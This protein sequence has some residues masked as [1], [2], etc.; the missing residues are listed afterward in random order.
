MKVLFV[1]E[2]AEDHDVV[3]SILKRDFPEVK[4]VGFKGRRGIF[5]HLVLD[6]AF[7]LM[8]LECRSDKY[9]P[10]ELSEDIIKSFGNRRFLFVGDKEILE[11]TIVS[12]V[13]LRKS[14]FDIYEKPYSQSQFVELLQNILRDV[15][16]GQI[17]QILKVNSK[18]LF[19]MGVKN[20][21]LFSKVPHD[22]FVELSQNKFI[23][24]ISKNESYPQHIIKELVGRNVRE[25]Y[26]EKT[27]YIRF[28]EESM[29]SAGMLMF[30][31]EC[32]PVKIFQIQ[33]SSLDLIHQYVK[34]IGVS[35]TV[36]DL[37]DKVIDA[38]EENIGA[39]E[40]FYD[41]FYMFPFEERDVVEK[42]ILI[43]Y[44]CEMIVRSLKWNSE[45]ARRQLGLASIIHD[46][47]VEDKVLTNI[48]SLDSEEF[49]RLPSS[50]KKKF[51]EH[52]IRAASLA[53]QFGGFSNVEFL[54][55]E[56]HELPGG[57]GF[58]QKKKANRI[59]GVSCAFIM[60]V[61]FVNEMAIQGVSQESVESTL[62]YFEK[63]YN[64]GFFKQV[65]RA[66]NDCLNPS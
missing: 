46:C 6:S 33:I 30:Q 35:H 8:V 11:K 50:M 5:E 66:F 9:N 18:N 32:S 65:L 27:S 26:V 47:F 15:N 52:P 63:N 59:S 10:V 43:L 25:L 48:S 51:Q 40:S 37:V 61:N 12:K 57:T 7:H 1:S 62:L 3:E 55:E 28:L 21:Y 17:D 23:K 2:D 53:E 45:I 42:S 38:T 4:L 34:N 56:H 14:N 44:V 54:I 31:K 60:A 16:D 13:D 24:V 19:P 29:E 58:P 36:I 41:I 49:K 20:F 64:V 22:A 39:F